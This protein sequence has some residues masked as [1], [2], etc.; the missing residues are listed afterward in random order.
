M[1]YQQREHEKIE[2]I[3]KS[4]PIT[5]K[6]NPGEVVIEPE[7]LYSHKQT[8][9]LLKK[10]LTSEE[11]Q[12]TNSRRDHKLKYGREQRND[13]RDRLLPPRYSKSNR[14]L[15]TASS[16]SSWPPRHTEIRSRK[17]QN[18][19]TYDEDYR[20]ERNFTHFRQR[21]YPYFDRP[22]ENYYSRQ[23]PDHFNHEDKI[24]R[25]EMELG[26]AEIQRGIDIDFTTN[27]Y[28]QARYT[29]DRIPRRSRSREGKRPPT[30]SIPRQ[31]TRY[32]SSHA[33]LQSIES[34][35]DHNLNIDENNEFSY[36][37]FDRGF[38]K[39]FKNTCRRLKDS[40]E[41][42]DH[43]NG[44][45]H[46]SSVQTNRNSR[47]KI[48]KSM[49]RQHIISREVSFDRNS[50][51]GSIYSSRGPPPAYDKIICSTPLF[52]RKEVVSQSTT[53][54]GESSSIFWV[55]ECCQIFEAL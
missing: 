24:D 2:K 34:Q 9:D 33:T 43:G 38:A 44:T 11:Q 3:V 14:E 55:V 51:T 18:Y 28:L 1:F 47:R 40:Y 42:Q 50:T 20:P 36:N 6:R 49:D 29:P 54:L 52:Y 4:S 15:D 27:R 39:D 35:E 32:H 21:S 10:L 25:L 46:R 41:A 48:S 22:T 7:D 23:Y 8:N 17:T 12:F 37:S 5:S 13:Y 30:T 16:E 31:R 53:I 26:Q 45:N 19:E